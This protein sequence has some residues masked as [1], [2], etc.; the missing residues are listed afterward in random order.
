[1]A[2]DTG[3]ILERAA[4]LFVA[5]LEAGEAVWQQNLRDVFTSMPVTVTDAH[6]VP[7]SG[8]NALVLLQTMMDRGWRDPRWLTEKQINEAGATLSKGAEAVDV[9]YMRAIGRDGALLETPETLT[10]AVFNATQIEG[11]KPWVEK[12]R[13]WS[14]KVLAERLLPKFGVDIVHDQADKAFFSEDDGKVH[15]P[16]PAAFPSIGDY[17]GVAVHE[18]SHATRNETDRLVD[19]E[20][21]Q[22]SFAREELR[23]E[24]ASM[25]LSIA[26]GIPH[27]VQRHAGFA[28]EWADLLRNDPVELFRAAR[29]AEKMAALVL[30]HVKA[31]EREMGVEK[32]FANPGAFDGLR[33]FADVKAMAEQINEMQDLE[34]LNQAVQDRWDRDVRQIEMSDSD[35]DEWANLLGQK[36]AQIETAET[37]RD[38][39]LMA[40]QTAQPPKVEPANKAKPAQD[41]RR[42]YQRGVSARRAADLFEDRQCILAV[43]FAEKEEA[44]KL[45]AVFYAEQ[46]VWFVPA[47]VDLGPLKRWSA[48]DGQGVTGRELTTAEIIDAFK[49][50]MDDFGLVTELHSSDKGYFDDGKWHYVGVK[51]HKKGQRPGAFILNVSGRDGKPSG[52]MENKLNG[53]KLGWTMD[54]PDLTPEQAARMR[55]EALAREEKAAKEIAERHEAVSRESIEIWS[56]T[57]LAEHGYFK[58]KGID[59]HGVPVISGAELL[60]YSAFKNDEG[61][62]IIR[63]RETYALVPLMDEHQKI[64]ALQAISED[65]KTKAFMSGGRKKGLFCVLNE[66][67]V[68]GPLPTTGKLGWAEGFATGAD[69]FEGTGFP[70]LICFDAGNMEAV[71]RD[72]GQRLSPEVVNVIG[73]DNDQFFLEKA[74]GALAKIG[75]VAYGE[76][77]TVKVVSGPGET[78]DVPLG[79][80]IADGEWHHAPGGRYRVR[81][82]NDGLGSVDRETGEVDGCVGKVTAELIR[83]ADAEQQK[84]TIRLG[85]RGLEAAQ[86]VAAAL[87]GKSIVVVPDFK[88]AGGLAGRPT[89]WND[90]AQR[91][92]DVGR[93]VFEQ[94]GELDLG[95]G[96]VVAREAVGGRRGR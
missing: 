89:D 11:L 57:R 49:K 30:W 86:V 65:G 48:I 12:A 33:T 79:Q 53:E 29:D 41:R 34:A 64:W 21:G 35:W 95:R 51:G 10:Y 18:L 44:K 38:K 16:P 8:G 62:S 24:L 46:K 88:A 72:V 52:Y 4:E 17:V 6:D 42:A 87:P 71:A 85:N 83:T 70:T 1:M 80:V 25:Q 61:K 27:D 77:P 2:F 39:A 14:L 47:G 9:Q 66:D 91:G 45:G 94:I 15:M 81:L 73:A 60:N 19:G 69:L 50:A 23:A 90:L 84:E 43:P 58:L 7:L 13:G 26:L 75:V 31:V 40:D 67:G 74:F 63:S 28:K 68:G 32:E 82:E 59:G 20:A 22:P 93:Q 96:A 5:R 55:A 36:V 56:K 92:G 78:R 37:G 3:E 54:T 76:G